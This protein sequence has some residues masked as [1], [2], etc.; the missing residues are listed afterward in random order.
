MSTRQRTTISRLS[1]S[2][3]RGGF[4]LIELLIGVVVAVIIMAA[5]YKVQV[6]QTQMYGQQRELMQVRGSLRAGVALMAWEVRQASAADGDIY[7]MDSTSI[8][9]RSV[10]GLGTLCTRDS[11]LPKFGIRGTP[12][13]MAATTDD[14]VLVYAALESTWKVLRVTAAGT[15]AS[16]GV[17]ACDWT[18]SG[19]PDIAV[20]LGV[21]AAS[22]TSGIEIGGPIR[23]FRRVEYGL[24]L[25]VMDGRWWL[26]RKVGAAASYEKLTGPLQASGGLLITYSDSTGAPTADPAQVVRINFMLRAESYGLPAGQTDYE[27]DSLTTSV[28]VRG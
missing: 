15:P 14:S 2:H 7:A 5:V 23:A 9:L 6:V 18:G 20:S 4:T 22:D 12:G 25:D 24:Y 28:A 10:Q 8:T 3:R 17:G 19:D 13:A 11:V 16:L 1:Q 27:V 26:G 21:V